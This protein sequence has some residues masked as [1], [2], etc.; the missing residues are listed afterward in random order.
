MQLTSGSS[1]RLPGGLPP[2]ASPSSVRSCF[3]MTAQTAQGRVGREGRSPGRR[4]GTRP[5]YTVPGGNTSRL[6]RL[7]IPNPVPL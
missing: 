5:W 3:S 1:G 4:P 2:P 7:H 6:H